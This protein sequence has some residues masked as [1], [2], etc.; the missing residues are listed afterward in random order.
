MPYQMLVSRGEGEVVPGEYVCSLFD[1]NGRYPLF[2]EGDG[3]FDFPKVGLY[4]G[5]TPQRA[6]VRAANQ[7]CLNVEP[8]PRMEEILTEDGEGKTHYIR[9]NF[10]GSACLEKKGEFMDNSG[11]L[12]SFELMSSL[13]AFD[14]ARVSKRARKMILECTPLAF[15]RSAGM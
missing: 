4:S 14:N 7:F 15:T 6:A 11:N 10:N 5:E 12:Y 2:R 3:E 8:I 13:E 1:I 9:C